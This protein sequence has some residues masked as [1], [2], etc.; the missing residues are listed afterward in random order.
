ME[1]WSR[2]PGHSSVKG[3]WLPRPY[4]HP[5]CPLP[6]IQ[7][8]S[9]ERQGDPP[10]ENWLPVEGGRHFSLGCGSIQKDVAPRCCGD[11]KKDIK[12]THWGIWGKLFW[13]DKRRVLKLCC[14]ALSLLGI[15]GPG[16]QKNRMGR[17]TEQLYKRSKST[18]RLQWE[19]R[20][21]KDQEL[22]CPE[23]QV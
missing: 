11:T 18:K 5:R 7:G 6:W 8:S 22:R 1:A 20:G 12:G 19:N 16:R 17:Q 4:E 14:N 15:G 3:R 13:V 2:I 23:Y 21:W 9:H 10:L